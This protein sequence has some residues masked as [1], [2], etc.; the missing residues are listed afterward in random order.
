MQRAMARQAEAE[1]EKRAKLISADA[2]LQRAEKLRDAS[3]MLSQSPSAISLAYLQ[4]MSEISS[5]TTQ[6]IVFPLPLDMIK[7]FIQAQAKEAAQ[8]DS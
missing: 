1:R 5:E 6:T 7:P 8:K 2:E 4:T 3:N